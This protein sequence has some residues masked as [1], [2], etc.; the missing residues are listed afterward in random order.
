MRLTRS[1]R[2]EVPAKRLRCQLSVDPSDLS[3]LLSALLS[4]LLR[5]H[6]EELNGLLETWDRSNRSSEIDLRCLLRCLL[7]G[8]LRDWHLQLVLRALWP[9]AT[10]WGSRRSRRSSLRATRWS[11]RR[12]T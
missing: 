2:P 12:S 6:A 11:S 4:A 8:R 3:D 5:E 7:R 10:L 9:A 1:E